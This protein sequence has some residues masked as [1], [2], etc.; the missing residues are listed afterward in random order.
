MSESLEEMVKFDLSERGITGRVLD[1]FRKV[2]RIHFVPEYHREQAYDDR[3]LPLT[4]GQTISQPYM[5]ALMLR[6]LG[7]QGNEKVLEIGTG[8]GYQTALLAQLCREVWT[9]ERLEP[10]A[11]SAEDRLDDL[12]YRNVRYHL[13][14]GSLGWPEGAPYERVLVSAACPSIP[15]ALVEQLEEGG[16]IVAP[17]GTTEGQDLMIGTKRNGRLET[18]RDTPCVFVRLIGAQGFPSA[19]ENKR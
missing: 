11:T 6:A 5:V 10:L 4:Y 17:V 7:L 19:S 2:D 9:V 8:S 13:A 14:D 16:L 18:R 1:A 12:G 3:A 15:P